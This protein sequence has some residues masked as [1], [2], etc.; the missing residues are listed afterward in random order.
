M[1]KLFSIV[2]FA[3]LGPDDKVIKVKGW[4]TALIDENG[5]QRKTITVC[6]WWFN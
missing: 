2:W 5:Y 6:F 3:W 4:R 1:N